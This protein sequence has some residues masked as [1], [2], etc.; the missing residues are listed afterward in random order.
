MISV[1]LWHC[2]NKREF[3]CV[4]TVKRLRQCS[5]NTMSQSKL[6]GSN[7]YRKWDIDAHLADSLMDEKSDYDVISCVCCSIQVQVMRAEASLWHHQV[8]VWRTSGPCPLLSVR[9]PGEPATTL[10]TFTVSGWLPPA[11]SPPRWR[12]SS[13]RGGTSEGATSAWGSR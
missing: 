11:T 12:R 5:S 9:G 8:A 3:N 4:M 2:M 6:K 10:P 1:V 13:S 7:F